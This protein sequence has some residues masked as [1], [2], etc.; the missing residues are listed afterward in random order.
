MELALRHRRQRLRDLINANGW[1]ETLVKLAKA[2]Q[3]FE[4][5]RC[6]AVLFHRLTFKYNGD[7]WYDVHPLVAEL[8]EFQRGLDGGT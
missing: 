6:L 8:P 2:K 5:D 1:T 3:I 7:G 4:D